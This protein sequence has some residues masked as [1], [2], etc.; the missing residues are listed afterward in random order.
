M[1][2]SIEVVMIVDPSNG[3][4][5]AIERAAKIFKVHGRL[6]RIHKD[7]VAHYYKVRSKYGRYK[8]EQFVVGEFNHPSRNTLA[9]FISCIM[10]SDGVNLMELVKSQQPSL[11]QDFAFENKTEEEKKE[12]KK[13]KSCTTTALHSS[14]LMIY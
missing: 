1:S 12:R 11:H 8:K 3:A 7:D 9:L 5:I 2:K 13:R 6:R 10:D 14:S 4:C